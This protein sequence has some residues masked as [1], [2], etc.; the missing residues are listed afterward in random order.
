M[1]REEG[2]GDE[3]GGQPRGITGRAAGVAIGGT[4]RT[5]SPGHLRLR[6]ASGGGIWARR[7]V[8]GR[9]VVQGAS[10]MLPRAGGPGATSGSRPWVE[11]RVS[12]GFA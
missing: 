10:V 11:S 8:I 2:V 1:G 6:R 12:S 4:G 7:P 9:F 5:R 3:V